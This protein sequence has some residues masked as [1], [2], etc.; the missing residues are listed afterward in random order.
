MARLCI[1]TP[2]QLG[3]NPRTVKEADAL[4]AAGHDVTVIAT[5]VLDAVE[6]RDRAVMAA[7]RWRVRRLDFS[8][9]WRRRADRLLQLAAQRLHGWTGIAAFAPFAHSEMSR[10][11]IRAARRTPADL[12]IAHY[13]AALPAAAL[14]AR[15][16]GARYAFDAEDF[17]TGD[18][19]DAPA[20]DP[21]RRAV[22]AIERRFLPAA[23]YVSAASPGIAQAY[24]E[25]YGIALPETILNVFPRASAPA[26]LAPVEVQLAAPSLY[27]FSQTIGPD[28]G[29]ESAI[30][31]LA[32]TRTRPQLVLRGMVTP[33]IAGTLRGIAAAAGVADRLTLLPPDAPGEM[34]RLAARHTLGLAGEI[35]NTRNRRIALTNKQFTYLL[36]GLPVLM[37][38]IPAH[39]AFAKDAPGAVFLYRAGDAASLAASIDALLGDPA[40]LRHARVAAFRLGQERFNWEAEHRKLVALVAN[41][42]ANHADR[43]AD[44]RR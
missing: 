7:A 27:W 19:P 3:S 29:L 20:F 39:R 15:Q 37:S 18:L 13:P 43:A 31:A 34:E 14:A 12:Y 16:H 8:R 10:R 11:L 42:L 44:T 5:R 9:P 41:A 23:A 25:E 24:R 32:L 22:A 28:R 17:H 26:A 38:D 1:I 6:P 33:A 36:A 35:G 21:P 2:G 4:S 40:A 30:A